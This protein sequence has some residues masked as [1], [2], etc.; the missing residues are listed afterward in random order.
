MLR[1]SILNSLWAA[2]N[3]KAQVVAFNEIEESQ[4]PDIWASVVIQA[5]QDFGLLVEGLKDVLSVNETGYI[6]SIRL[7]AGE[8]NYKTWDKIY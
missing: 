8:T 1:A 4:Y 3:L 2:R 6:K 5:C 7:C